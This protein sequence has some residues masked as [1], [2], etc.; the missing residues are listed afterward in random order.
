[1]TRIALLVRSAIAAKTL[2]D[3]NLPRRAAAA[4]LAC[5]AAATPV[6]AQTTVID[7]TPGSGSASGLS[8]INNRG[9]AVGKAAIGSQGDER[10]VVWQDGTLLDLAALPD[11]PLSSAAAINERGQ[12]V[13]TASDGFRSRAVL[14]E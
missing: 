3:P 11:Y 1:M 7:I 6:A 2:L 13:G 10:A 9:Q 4:L 5:L 14:W 12:I 8:D